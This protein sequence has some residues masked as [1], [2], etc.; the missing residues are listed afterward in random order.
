MK[1]TLSG[2]ALRA[3]VGWVARF[4]PSK[5]VTPV[6]AGILIEASDDGLTLTGFDFET[7]GV[8][9]VNATVI[10]PGRTLVSGHLLGA[11]CKTLPDDKP[12]RDGDRGEGGVALVDDG[13]L[14][15][16]AGKVTWRLPRMEVEDYPAVPS[17]GGLLGGVSGE[18]MRRVLAAVLPACAKPDSQLPVITGVAL[19]FGVG[20]V[21]AVGTNRYHLAAVELDWQSALGLESQSVVLSDGLSR[22]VANLPGSGLVGLASDGSVFTAATD[23]HQVTGRLLADEFVSYRKLLD[24]E[25]AAT[26]VLSTEELL[27]AVRQASVVLGQYDPLRLSFGEEGV[28]VSGSAETGAA[29]DATC[30]VLAYEGEPREVWVNPDYLTDAVTGAGADTVH[31]TLPVKSTRGFLVQPMDVDEESGE[32]VPRPGHCHLIMTMKARS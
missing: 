20:G 12:R 4:C 27:A 11:I 17:S 5:P 3:A 29:G 30:P 23:T 25:V 7:A 22:A 16:T 15:I 32:S 14:R 13:P 9:T 31:L 1:V 19:T 10:E 2:D 8:V 24:V 18:E 21:E 28:S 26:V 6:V